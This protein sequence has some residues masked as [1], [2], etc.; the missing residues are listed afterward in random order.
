MRGSA[1]GKKKSR[2][3]RKYKRKRN[4]ICFFIDDSDLFT[5]NLTILSKRNTPAVGLGNHRINRNPFYNQNFINISLPWWSS[6]KIIAIRSTTNILQP[7]IYGKHDLQMCCVL[8]YVFQEI[9]T[10]KMKQ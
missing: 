7:K 3:K 1:A 9:F 4:Y 5:K 6:V 2:E 8:L 10:G